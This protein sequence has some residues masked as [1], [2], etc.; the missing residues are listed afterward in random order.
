MD[1]ITHG[2]IGGIAGRVFSPDSTSSSYLLVAAI[3]A[4]FP[5]IDYLLFWVNP[6]QFITEWHRGFTHSLVLLPVWSLLL[7]LILYP[8]F[9][10]RLAFSK[11]LFFTS[12]GLFTHIATDFVT[13]YGVQLFSPEDDR[14]FALG[15]TF[16][17]DPWLG[18]LA[19]LTLLIGTIHR[20]FVIVGL[21]IIGTYLGTLYY[22][23][24]TALGIIESRLKLDNSTA[25]HIYALPEPL[26][27]WHWRLVIDRGDYYEISHL[28]L[29]SDASDKLHNLLTPTLD[30]NFTRSPAQMPDQFSQNKL[31]RAQGYYRDKRMLVWRKL[32]KF[33]EN[34]HQVR[35]ARQ[36]WKHEELAKFRQ[37]ATMAVMYRIDQ[38]SDSECVWFTDLRYVL[39]VIKPPFRYGMCQYPSDEKWRLYRLKRGSNND[40]E[41]INPPLPLL[42]IANNFMDNLL[43]TWNV[44]YNP[45]N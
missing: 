31:Y 11:I 12:L 9:K 27:P 18:L 29:A 2:L 32:F 17:I 28:S 33:G 34:K 20:L 8:L 44:T 38:T 7:S 6:Y 30:K 23:Q 21:L 15:I 4:T 22:G 42:T 14:R 25:D 36:V 16:D 45:R 10:W 5:D 40:R 1:T 13:L 41:R 37:F 35:L 24:Q 19:L 26:V 3:A 39:P 43:G